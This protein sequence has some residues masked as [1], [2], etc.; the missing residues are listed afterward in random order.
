MMMGYSTSWADTNY[1]ELRVPNYVLPDV[2]TCEDGSKVTS[3]EI[4]EQKRRPELLEIFLSQEY[5]YTPQG[6]V[7]VTY[8]VVAEKADAIDGLATAQQVM[9]TFSGQ[10]REVKALALVYIPN[11]REGKVPVFIGYNFQGNH[12]TTTDQW[13]RYSPYFERL[14]S[15][16]PLLGRGAQVA[17]WPVKTIVGR[18]Y[19]VV[20]MCYHDIYPDNA[21]GAS[22]SI[23]PLL[24]QTDEA[25]SRW[26]AIGAWAWGSSRIAD[27]VEQQPWANKD[28][29][30]I[31]GHSR[32]GKAA[33]WA[34]VQDTRFKVVISSC[35]GCGG[36]ALSKRAFG[37]TINDVTTNFP[38]WFCQ[39]FSNYRN[40]E[41]EMP[42]DQHE[43]L[44]LVAPRH[45]YVASASEDSWAD[46]KGEYL[47]LYHASPVY[48]LY[49]MTGL[50]SPEMPGVQEPIHNDVGH[51][52]RSGAHNILV[53]DWRNYLDFCDKVYGRTSQH[54][55]KDGICT[56][57]GELDPNY[58]T[59][60]SDGFYEIS[61]AAEL[62]WFA[63]M[64]NRG[65][66]TIN[67]LLTA[68][69]DMTGLPT[70]MI[71][72]AQGTSFMGVFDGQGHTIK[73]AINVENTG[74]YSGSLFRFVKDA[75]FRNLQLTGSVTTRGKHP[76]SLISAAEGKVLLER[77]ISDCDIYTNAGD[78]CMGGL[79]GLAGENDNGGFAAD[80]TFNCCAF[81]GTITHTGDASQNHGGLF[82]GWK[83]NKN[84]S[85]TVRNSFTAAK[86]ITNSARFATFVRVWTSTDNG[87]TSFE[88][89]FY[90]NDISE[91]LTRQ[92]T[93]T[94]AEK[95]KSGEVCYFMNEKKTEEQAW[96]QTIGD[97]DFP[98]LDNT[99][100]TVYA[101]PSEGFLCDGTPM[102]ETIYSNSSPSTIVPSHSFYNGICTKCG[103]LD[104]EYKTPNI[105]GFYELSDETDLT[106][107][108]TMVNT[109]DNTINALVTEDINYTGPAIGSPL[110]HFAGTFDGQGHRITYT[111]EA[112]EAIW[113]L[114]RTVSGTVKNLYVDGTI[115]MH[116]NE[117]GGVVGDLYGGTLQNIV[118]TT[119]I[120]SD[121]MGDSAYGGIISRFMQNG[122]VVRDCVFAGSIQAPDAHSCGGIVGWTSKVASV[123]NCLMVGEINAGTSSG[124]VI[125]RSSRT[126]SI[127]NCYDLNPYA[128][129]PSQAKQVTAEQLMS[130]EVGYALN[131]MTSMNPTWFQRLEEDD[132]P[133]PMLERGVIY[134]INGIY[135]NAYDESSFQAF[136]EKLA[137]A[138]MDYVKGVFA[139]I[140]L[141]EE[142]ETLIN[143]KLAKAQ[144]VEELLAAWNEIEPKAKVLAESEKA[145][146]AYR[147]KVE[148]MLAD[149]QKNPSLQNVKRDKLE[150]YLKEYEEP[151]DTYP[152]GTAPYIMDERL[153]GGEALTAEI[154]WM[155][156][157]YYEALLYSPAAGTDITRL[158]VNA[159]FSDGF[160]GWEGQWGT[161]TGGS[162][163]NT[164][165]A[166]ECYN[167]TMDIHQTLT[168]MANGLYELQVNGTYRPYPGDDR[169]NL[170]YA[171]TLYANDTQNYFMT[172]IE[173]M[174]P[175]EEAID[176]KNCNLSGEIP[177]F[178]VENMDGE[179]I[180]Y[181]PQGIMGIC[182]AISVN[183]YFN[184]VLCQVTDGRLTVGIRLPDRGFR[185]EALGFGNIRLI[186]HGTVDEAGE[187]LDRVLA[188]QSARA[189]TLANEYTPGTGDDFACY[190]NFSL[191]LK[192]QMN[193]AIEAVATATGEDKLALMGQFSNLF[194]EAYDCKQAY[195]AY[196]KA[197][198]QYE[199]GLVA[200][201]DA[202]FNFGE[203]SIE[204]LF[205]VLSD[206]QYN[207][208]TGEYS[209]EEALAQE[210]LKAMPYYTNVF[211][212][213]PEL[214]DGMYQ[215]ASYENM[216]W[217]RRQIAAG[218]MGISA[219]LVEDIDL[220]SNPSFMLSEE[221]AKAFSGVFDGQ[222]HTIKLAI[223]VKNTGNYS[224]ALFRYCRNATF[225]N[226]HLTGSVTT[227]G[228]HP[229]SL[230]SSTWG[231]NIISNVTSDC[232]IYTDASDACMGGLVGLVGENENAEATDVTFNNCAFT[233]SITHTGD[234]SQNHG[235]LFVGWKGN[236]NT[237]VTVRNSYSAAKSITNSARFATFVRFW[238]STDNGRM[239]FENCFYVN[240]ISEWLAKQGTEKSAEDF[241][242]GSV[243]YN[244]N[245]NQSEIVWYQTLGEDPYPVLDANHGQ[246]FRN[247]DG[248]YGNA[249]HLTSPLSEREEVSDIFDLSGR[250]VQRSR[251]KVQRGLYIVNGKKVM[252]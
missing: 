188:S 17:R 160:N 183:R 199:D 162:P 219:A 134:C 52:I 171:A 203:E 16:D 61:D 175:A 204:S 148:E 92:G 4:W 161:G 95:F 39:N 189:N 151:G 64:V 15:N 20:T 159:D 130:G 178:A 150:Y 97:D 192:D 49:G 32:Q 198:S 107:F 86:S 46:P 112:S 63:E 247:D 116:T 124:N 232:D 111:A 207:L 43:L 221:N 218:N 136:R 115:T 89:C 123:V 143:E 227:A 69:I 60:N 240:D 34:G 98:V 167:S 165:R 26:Q 37:E 6:T 168:D 176:G 216:M 101:N 140:A 62:N 59:L 128:A 149:L 222:G 19:A 187:A 27:W 138:E 82:V 182:N 233:G 7:N 224:G 132:Y 246:V 84:A 194:Q 31:V 250:R 166:A 154:V 229:A 142:Y 139:Q 74:N 118:C 133:T 33:I 131:G 201:L 24:P 83:G 238:S 230:V 53:Y 41:Q 158:L 54:N 213:V 248:T 177:D 73:L 231:T 214:V 234:A 163:T 152:N 76:A 127:T 106:W 242:S 122:G 202:G 244:L 206:I 173:D 184:S 145:Y 215:I 105:E 190:A 38:H 23:I 156:E 30:N 90:I 77:V 85:V 21:S 45:I 11:R 125:A 235:G 155:D 13:V 252:K 119:N 169:Q 108:A 81:T 205:T 3:T 57:C 88:N 50:T 241:A 25:G 117:C 102:G 197:C 170:N 228:K 14:S 114:F 51:H 164:M 210:A 212:S 226:L 10:G 180:G 80:V 2:L 79:V 120:V 211:G 55:Y 29:M 9:F 36:A 113:G 110:S 237:S 12:N 109:V 91:W 68:D 195:I 193:D 8:E 104:R 35:S 42:F 144:D 48:A 72:I 129:I 56:L 65:D 126:V 99:H 209:F 223:N 28:Q 225:R 103:L 121:Y 67:G 251:F 200:M 172:T 87:R 185:G 217:L 93:E 58:I 146:T 22:Q 137:N 5:G 1:D 239:S 243:C 135:G 47:A 78:A 75:T 71:G 196:F 141:T 179:V 147:A 44:A 96:F 186:Y 153:P 94:S 70:C 181:V 249:S 40:K 157:T 18:G 191:Q 174:I 66:N 245:G 236:R 208:F 100:K 220:T